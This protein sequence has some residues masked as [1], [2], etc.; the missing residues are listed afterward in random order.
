MQG[1]VTLES[2][3]GWWLVEEDETHTLY[4]IHHSSVHQ[5]RNLHEFDIVLFEVAPNPRKPGFFHAV[6]VRWVGST[7]PRRGTFANPPL[8]VG[9]KNGGQQR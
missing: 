5:N 7:A 4:F 9:L 3:K 6:D 1:V 8:Q 2:K